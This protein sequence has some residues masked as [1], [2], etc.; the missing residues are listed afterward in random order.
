[1]NLKVTQLLVAKVYGLANRKY[2]Q[3]KLRKTWACAL[4]VAIKPEIILKTALDTQPEI[5]LKTALDTQHTLFSN[6]L[7]KDGFYVSCDFHGGEVKRRCRNHTGPSSI[8]G[9]GCQW[10]LVVAL[11][12]GI[13]KAE[14]G[15]ISISCKNF[16]S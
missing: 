6:A 11:S 1:M 16:F 10:D 15:E 13:D 8:L 9:S 4:A 5:I 14:S 12:I 3:K 7:V 2:C